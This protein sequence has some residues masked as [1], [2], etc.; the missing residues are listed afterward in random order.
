[1]MKNLLAA[2]CLVV[3]SLAVP[4][5]AVAGDV[6]TDSAQAVNFVKD[7]VITTKVKAKL[8]DEKMSSLTRIGVDTDAAGA[9]YLSGRA[10]SQREADK[11]VSIARATDGVTSVKSTIKVQK[12]D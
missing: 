11:A 8:A 2:T 3:G 9:V 12:G 4:V 10:D 5:L 7:S 6:D 1:M